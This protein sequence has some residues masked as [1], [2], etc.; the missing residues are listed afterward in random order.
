M[1][2]IASCLTIGLLPFLLTACGTFEVTFL[3]P[4][5][6]TTAP[7]ETPTA[8]SA[9]PPEQCPPFLNET[10]LPDHPDDPQSYIGHHYNELNMPEGLTFYSGMTLNDDYLTE[11]VG[12]PDFDMQFIAQTVCHDVGGAPYNTVVDAVKIPQMGT[13]YG[14]ATACSTI[15]D[16]GPI[17]VYGKFDD[18]QPETTLLGVQGWSMYDLDFGVQINL[19]TMR[20]QP[21]SL[22]GV[23]CIHGSGLGS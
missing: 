1:K 15:P 14:R 8:P 18:T 2:S 21:L 13:N 11:W 6:S 10:V 16:V 22:K 9:V 7:I 5:S 20:F 19:H 17:V 3:P 4:P 12:R 23:E